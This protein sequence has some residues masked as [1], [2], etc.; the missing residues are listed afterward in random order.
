MHL[1][2]RDNIFNSST[3]RHMKFQI[4]FS[5]ARFRWINVFD[6]MWG[7]N[8]KTSAEDLPISSGERKICGAGAGNWYC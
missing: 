3:T 6:V 2:V 7:K 8:S 4:N 5:R 1:I